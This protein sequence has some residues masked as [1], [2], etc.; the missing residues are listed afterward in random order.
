MSELIDNLLDFAR[1][2]LGGGI[3]LSRAEN[4]DIAGVLNQ[5]IMELQTASPQRTI[6]R[7]IHISRH[8]NC[9][10]ARIGQLL[11]N[12]LANAV[13]HGDPA[14][15]I[16]VRAK[17]TSDAFEM[18]VTNQGQTIPPHILKQLFLPF[19]RGSARPGQQGLGLGL[20]I[21]DQI[22]RAHH[23]AVNVVSSDGQTCFTFTIPTVG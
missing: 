13:T 5:V 7:D 19:A 11:S 16:M 9:D 6:H 12:L 2:R 3:T 18:S 21:A 8:V 17:T 10:S 1:G 15:P 20:Y 4:A 23:G 22:A 14:T